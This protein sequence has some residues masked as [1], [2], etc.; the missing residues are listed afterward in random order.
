RPLLSTGRPRELAAGWLLPG[1]GRYRA[2]GLATPGGAPELAVEELSARER[3]VV[4]RVAEMMSTEEIA[5]DLHVSVNTVKTHL[6]SIYR[7]LAVTRR[8]EAVR[9]ARE[10]RLL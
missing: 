6:K 7:K 2:P 5:A 3:D 1:P 10:R 8:G 4:R 9:R